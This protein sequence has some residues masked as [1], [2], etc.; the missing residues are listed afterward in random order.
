MFVIVV[1]QTVAARQGN[2][3]DIAFV[4]VLV[5]RGTLQCISPGLKLRVLPDGGF[6]PAQR[7]EATSDQAIFV[8]RSDALADSEFDFR[9]TPGSV[10]V[11][12][13]N[14]FSDAVGLYRPT[15]LAMHSKRYALFSADDTTQ[16][17][18]I[19]LSAV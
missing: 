3:A 11:T 5:F 6:F 17:P 2:L 12:P 9:L 8:N 13:A 14:G 16:S 1:I 10:D 7:V 18:A 15:A 19:L 4:V